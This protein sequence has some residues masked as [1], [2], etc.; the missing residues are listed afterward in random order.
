MF[1]DKSVVDEQQPAYIEMYDGKLMAEDVRAFVESCDQVITIGTLMTDFNTGAFTARLDPMKTIEIGHHHTRV[2]SQ[3]YPNV[4]MA[5]ILTDLAG[6][7][8]RRNGKP[9]S[10][11]LRSDRSW[12]ATVTRSLLRHRI[13]VGQISCGQATSSSQRLA[14]ALWGWALL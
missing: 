7:V 10:N 2:G 9:P 12:A 13:L 1:G 11:L 14:H 3:A 6:R 4:E 8:T 5:D